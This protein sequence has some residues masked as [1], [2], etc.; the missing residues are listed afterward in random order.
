MIGAEINDSNPPSEQLGGEH[1]R[2]A[3]GHREHGEV[4][5]RGD[6][7]GVEG[8]HGWDAL[9]ARK[10]WEDVSQRLARSTVRAQP[11]EL[12]LRMGVEQSQRLGAGVPTHPNQRDAHWL[13]S[14]QA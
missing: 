5:R 9:Y 13:A 7:L 4:R 12:N 8:D 11:S 2:G 14:G 6:V 3:M 1:L 10:G